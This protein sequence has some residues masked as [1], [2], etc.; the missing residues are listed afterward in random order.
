MLMM[1]HIFGSMK[2]TEIDEVKV[3]FTWVFCGQNAVK[4]ETLEFR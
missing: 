4:K 3:A 2:L 1:R